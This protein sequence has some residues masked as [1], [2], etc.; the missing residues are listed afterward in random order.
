MNTPRKHLVPYLWPVGTAGL[1]A[2]DRVIVAGSWDS[3]PIKHA[4]QKAKAEGRL[5]DLTY[6]QACKWVMFLDTGHLVLVS[7]P[8]PVAV[9]EE[10]GYDEFV[11]RK[12]GEDVP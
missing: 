1:V 4:A 7:V 8:M 2:P 12:H 6:G 10:E 3:A 11:I 9:L 5:I